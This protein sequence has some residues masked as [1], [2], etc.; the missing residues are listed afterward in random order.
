MALVGDSPEI[1]QNTNEGK[2][3]TDEMWEPQSHPTRASWGP[4]ALRRSA[5]CPE[6]MSPNP[7]RVESQTE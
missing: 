7:W 4:L 2:A 6:G 3:V 5:K 1:S